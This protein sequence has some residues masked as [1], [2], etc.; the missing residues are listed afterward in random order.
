M[1]IQ[2]FIFSKV[3]KTGKRAG[4]VERVEV[5]TYGGRVMRADSWW[6]GRLDDDCPLVLDLVDAIDRRLPVSVDFGYTN[7]FIFLNSEEISNG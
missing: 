7:D 5:A 4:Q 1:A 2:K 3:H 6:F